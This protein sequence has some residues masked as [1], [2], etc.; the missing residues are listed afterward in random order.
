M[1]SHHHHIHGHEHNHGKKGNPSKKFFLRFA[2][3]NAYISIPILAITIS[4]YLT[5]GKYDWNNYYLAFLFFST[6]F[7]YPLH[8]LMGLHLTIPLE[9]S[10]AQRSVHKNPII[11]RV[12]IIIGG[13][14]TLFFTFLLSKEVLQLL[15]PLGL[16]SLTYSLPLIPTSNG[17]KRLRDIPGIKIYAITIVVTITTSTIPLLLAQTESTLDIIFLG[18][19]RFL[20]I[21][22]ITIPF[23]VRDIR[24]DTKWS[25]KTI[26]ILLGKDNAI[27]LSQGLLGLTSVAVIIQ[28]FFSD[29]LSW[30][31]VVAIIISNAW[32]FYIIEKFKKYNA[33]L[34][35]AFMVEGT[36]VFQFA[37][38]TL[39]QTL[40]SF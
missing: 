35:N 18:V 20:F 14:G 3:S 16:I 40:M 30:S 4:T 21:L 5:V 15:I 28:F 17:W 10:Q 6:L 25:L 38:I 31:I 13:I 23:D 24:I 39:T 34:F 11:A 26:P 2:H 37:V 36:M 33:P 9:Y 19:Q 12:A 1:A 22:A 8:R 27:M 32:T 7:L 29:S